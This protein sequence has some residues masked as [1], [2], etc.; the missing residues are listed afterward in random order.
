[1][2]ALLN[3]LPRTMDMQSKVTM[4][5]FIT[6]GRALQGAEGNTEKELIT[7]QMTHLTSDRRNPYDGALL[8]LLAYTLCP[9][10][11]TRES[12]QRA[13]GEE[14]LTNLTSGLR[15]FA[16]V[17]ASSAADLGNVLERA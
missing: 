5:N 4:H 16:E 10:K 15:R 6:P 8:H 13:L 9:D 1:M 7:T 11:T 2:A 12:A 17:S 3:P 14:F